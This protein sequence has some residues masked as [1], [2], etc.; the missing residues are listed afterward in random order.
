LRRAVGAGPGDIRNQFLIEALVLAL[1]GGSMGVGLGLGTVLGIG[2]L[3]DLPLLVRPSSILLAAGSAAATGV[4]FG[5]YPAWRAA[6]LDPIR[7][8]RFE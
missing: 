2:A 8:L 1:L 6:R 4:F 5:L 7:A 3:I